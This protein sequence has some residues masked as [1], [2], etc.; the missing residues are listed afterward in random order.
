MQDKD[1]QV[2]NIRKNFKRIDNVFSMYR[3]IIKLLPKHL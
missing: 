3:P 2:A 1:F